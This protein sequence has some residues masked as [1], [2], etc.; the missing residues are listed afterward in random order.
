MRMPSRF[1][2]LA[3][4]VTLLSSSILANSAAQAAV[5]PAAQAEL[6]KQRQDR[7]EEIYRTNFWTDGDSVSGPGSNMGATERFRAGLPQV[8][9]DYGIGSILDAACGDFFWMREVPMD[10]IAYEGWDISPGVIQSDV[11]RYSGAGLGWSRRFYVGDIVTSPI[12]AVDLVIAR[13][14]LVHMSNRN[15]KRAINNIKASGSRYLLTTTFLVCDRAENLDI[16]DSDHRPIDL[17][18]APFHLPEPLTSISEQYDME[19]DICRNKVASL[20]DLSQ[21]PYQN[22]D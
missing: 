9:R 5:D 1:A 11:E 10:N 13:D 3:A 7:F 21:V 4:L 18:I 12:P 2:P 15:I 6:D 22:I 16:Q 17:R 20:W 19:R 8:L 14:V